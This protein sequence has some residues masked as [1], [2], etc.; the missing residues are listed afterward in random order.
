MP[1]VR[2]QHPTERNCTFTI[3]DATRPYTLPFEC[4]ACHR[5]HLFKTY[6]FT[7]DE[8]GAA[9]VSTEI[10]EYLKRIPLHD[11]R[12]ANEVQQPPEQKIVLPIARLKVEAKQV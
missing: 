3:V 5:V 7:L 10:N 12:V 2:I 1:G 9:I 8:T 4:P 11:F 6:H